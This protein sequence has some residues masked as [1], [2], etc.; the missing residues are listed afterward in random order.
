MEA[1]MKKKALSLILTA[2]LLAGMLTGCSDAALK[3]FES[4]IQISGSSYDYSKSAEFMETDTLIMTVGDSPVY[5]EEYYY[6]MM[7]GVM[8]VI[9]DTGA[10]TD[11]TQV[12]DKST[13][14]LGFELDLNEFIRY[15]AYDAVLMYRTIEKRFEQSGLTLNEDDVYSIERYMEDRGLETQEELAAELAGDNISQTLYEYIQTVSAE[16]FALL[17]NT[18]GQGGADCP[19]DEVM[20]YAASNEYIKVKHILL[21]DSDEAKTLLAQLQET[22][23][24]QLE[25]TFTEKMRER[26]EDSGL[27]TYPDGYLF[28]EGQMDDTF[29]QAAGNLGEGQLSEVVETKNGYHIILRLPINPDETPYLGTE[30]LRYLAASDRFDSIVAAW[31]TEMKVSYEDAFDQIIPSKIFVN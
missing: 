18:Y 4:S 21:G 1:Y 30:S 12:Y 17:E 25:Q 16:Y 24:Q 15:Y 19:D 8:N 28:T 9:N 13:E 20:A 14:V 6:W 23:A 27:E 7:V 29:G 26:S 10:I 2:A 3:Q 5:W 22:D 11:W 31:Q